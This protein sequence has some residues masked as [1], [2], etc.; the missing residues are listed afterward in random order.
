MLTS[1]ANTSTVLGAWHSSSI[2]SSHFELASGL[3]IYAHRFVQI[4]TNRV[5]QNLSQ[6]DIAV[7]INRQVELIPFAPSQLRQ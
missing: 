2:S 4:S 5:I 6:P 1:R 7:I 3:A